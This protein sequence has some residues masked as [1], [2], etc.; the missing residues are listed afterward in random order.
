M[1]TFL[2]QTACLKTTLQRKKSWF[3]ACLT[4]LSTVI[5][6]RSVTN[7]FIMVILVYTL[8]CFVKIATLQHKVC[9][10]FPAGVKIKGFLYFL[11]PTTTTPSSLLR[12][13]TSLFDTPVSFVSKVP[14]DKCY[15]KSY[16]AL[17]RGTLFRR[18]WGLVEMRW[19]GRGD[20]V[21]RSQAALTEGSLSCTYNRARP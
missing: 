17:D 11:P 6:Q 5:I 12:V 1:G 10:C 2:A 16:L 15:P 8:L 3:I 14:E 13:W 7:Y 19:E 18:E 20:P 21:K 9:I 4:N